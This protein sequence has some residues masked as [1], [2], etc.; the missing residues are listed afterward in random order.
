MA[1]YFSSKNILKA[2]M[3][4]LVAA[5]WTIA[6]GATEGFG[7]AMYA[8]MPQGGRG[9]G[10]ITPGQGGGFSK[11]KTSPPRSNYL[12]EH[13]DN[14]IVNKYKN[15]D[16]R[17]SNTNSETTPHG[18]KNKPEQDKKEE[19]KK[20]D[21]KKKGEEKDTGIKV[22]GQTLW[23]DGN[24]NRYYYVN[25]DKNSPFI[26]VEQKDGSFKWSTKN[27]MLNKAAPAGGLKQIGM[28]E[29]SNGKLAVMYETAG[30]GRAFSNGS[31]WFE[32]GK[33]QNSFTQVDKLTVKPAVKMGDLFNPKPGT[34]TQLGLKIPPLEIP[35]VE[36]LP[37]QGITAPYSGAGGAG[38]ALFGQRQPSFSDPARA[39]T[40]Y[41][42]ETYGCGAGANT[43]KTRLV[44]Y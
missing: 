29:T 23:E 12:D 40:R 5:V 36:M 17:N 19:E 37:S 27:A 15:G 28:I 16:P 7:Q 4:A 44:P 21:E 14:D 18:R 8:D 43:C 22:N 11:P 3:M 26:S 38:D 33:G 25:G 10:G 34:S 1:P 39:G 42:V 31:S 32:T 13:S 35:A 30:G 20:E 24:R 6:G 2:P 9:S 41:R